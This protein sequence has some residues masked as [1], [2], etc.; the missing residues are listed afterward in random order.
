M[1]LYNYNMSVAQLD[2]STGAFRRKLPAETPE[3]KV[4]LQPVSQTK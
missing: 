4:E 1:E 2:K 3:K